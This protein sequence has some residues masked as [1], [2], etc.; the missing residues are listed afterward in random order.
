M[1][2]TSKLVIAISILSGCLGEATRWTPRKMASVS[3]PSIV[4]WYLSIQIAFFL[5]LNFEVCTS[6]IVSVSLLVRPI[7]S[8]DHGTL[9]HM[10]KI[11]AQPK[12]PHSLS[13]IC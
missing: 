11:K 6:V 1:H 3:E 10:N 4:E 9:A 7:K 2:I 8:L 12:N 5:L 13:V